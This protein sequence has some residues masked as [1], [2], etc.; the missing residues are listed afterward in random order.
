MDIDGVAPRHV[1]HD[2][3]CDAGIDSRIP[4]HR[5]GDVHRRREDDV[6]RVGEGDDLTV[7][8]PGDGGRG[9]GIHLTGE[10]DGVVEGHVIVGV[11]IG[12]GGGW[13]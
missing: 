13:N 12:E 1:A 2:V 4:D 9:V 5:P 3:A 11:T 6:V 10:R 7:L 8:E